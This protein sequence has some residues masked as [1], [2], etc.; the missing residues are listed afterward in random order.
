[1]LVLD[2]VHH[3][4]SP[5]AQAVVMAIADAM[6]P[7]SQVVLAG[8]REPDLPI[9]RLRAQGRLVDLRAR[10]LV[11]TR[12]EAAMML[13]LGGLDLPPED[14]LV[15]LERT[16][17]WP[18]GLYLA[19]LSLRGHQ[20]V[21]RAVARFGGDDRL[22][23]DYV[24]DELLGRLD[25]EQ[26]AFLEGTS[27]LDELSGPLCDAVLH[28][29]GSGNVLRDMSR[30][31][32]LVVPLDDA[33]ASYRYHPLLADM[34]QAELRRAD[35]SARP[36]CTGGRATGTRA[37]AT[38][39]ARS[40]TRSTPATRSAPESCCGPRPHGVRRPQRRR[41]ALA[42]ALHARADRR[43]SDAR[44]HRRGP[45]PRA[46]RARPGRALDRRRRAA[47]R[48]VGARVAGRRGRDHARGRR[49][50][51]HRRD[52]GGRRERVR[53]PARGQ[54]VAVAVLPAAR[55][56]RAPAGRRRRGPG[57]SRG[58]R[59]PRRDRR[60]ERPGAVPGPARPAR[61]RGRRLG[62]GA[63]ARRAGSCAGRP[64]RQRAPPGRALVF[65]VS[66]LVRAH[67]ERVEDAQADR[68]RAVEA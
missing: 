45:A 58:G 56:R 9:G 54:P 64:L 59:S 32:L 19:A 28:R 30:S 21:H 42:R 43:P 35:R 3:L 14:V 53:A 38:P 50:G 4:R 13:S 15:L 2:D 63:A 33:D 17:G 55:R 16:E 12:R 47:A 49:P 39:T 36:S 20:D 67:R 7:G 6:P 26:L 52:G 11:M 34:L 18:A 48:R 65:A 22:L 66:A 8:R 23:A 31:N 51:R 29:R 41:A 25:D 27:V 37:P 68:R 61:A 24:R 1:M 40:T 60:A 10:D 5:E 62:A 44:A 46:R 57:P